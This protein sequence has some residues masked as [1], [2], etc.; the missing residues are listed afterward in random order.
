MSND[1][2]YAGKNAAIEDKMRQDFNAAQQAQ[3]QAQVVGRL[4][5]MSL[6]DYATQQCRGL[7][8]DRHTTNKPIDRGLCQEAAEI[9]EM[10][11]MLE[12]SV[13]GLRTQLFGSFPEA[14]ECNKAERDPSL[15]ETLV[16]AR[17]ALGRLVETVSLLR[18]K[19]E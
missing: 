18:S 8:S 3:L 13:F 9:L 11:H 17:V 5:E 1:Y 2:K 7:S 16:Q 10:I 12:G 14:G 19:S 6:S 4:P 15:S